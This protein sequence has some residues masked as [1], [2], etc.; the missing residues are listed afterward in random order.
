MVRTRWRRDYVDGPADSTPLSA[1]V[2]DEQSASV[3]SSGF[4]VLRDDQRASLAE[5]CRRFNRGDE[6]VIALRHAFVDDLALKRGQVQ[7][8]DRLDQDEHDHDRNLAQIRT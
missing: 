5:L 2:T 1:M 6:V 7:V 3:C 8:A 4:V